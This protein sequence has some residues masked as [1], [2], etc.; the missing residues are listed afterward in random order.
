MSSEK[1]TLVDGGILV[2]ARLAEGREETYPLFLDAT[3]LRGIKDQEERNDKA[4]KILKYLVESDIDGG[5]EDTP[6]LS[7]VIGFERRGYDIY[8]MSAEIKR[9]TVSDRDATLIAT[10]AMRK[11]ALDLG[12]YS[13]KKIPHMV[14]AQISTE[15]GMS[16]ETNPIASSTMDTDGMEYEAESERIS[17]SGHNLYTHEMQLICIS[18]IIALVKAG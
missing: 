10:R 15:S 14:Y 16:F 12:T 7:I 8:G 9:P 17:L 11:M 18:G 13:A 2:E 1:Y 5:E 4:G 3:A 6:D